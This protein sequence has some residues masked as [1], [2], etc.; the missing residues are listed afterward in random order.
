ME[1]LSELKFRSPELFWFGLVCLLL[2]FGLMLVSR[3]DTIQ[4]LGISAYIKPIKFSLSTTLYAWTMAW[5]CFYLPQFNMKP[6]VWSTIILLGFE[7]LYILVQA[8]KGQA[9][10]FNLSTPFYAVMYSFMAL[11]ASLVTIYTAYVC[12]LFFKEPLPQL[13]DYYV[14]GIRLGMLLFVIFSFQGFAMGSRLTH[15]IGA[16][17]GG[18]GIPFFNWSITAGDLRIAHFIGMHAL[19]VIPLI[20]FYVLK[21][22]KAT[23][24]LAAVYALVAFLSWYMAMRGKSPF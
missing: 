5:F 12:L 18:K 20:A 4:F 8:A 15:T 13:P 3:F 17:D 24:G 10:H 7:I 16:A 19:Q 22:T 9:S 21:N 1:F 11:A 14:W 2:A 6:F 23:F